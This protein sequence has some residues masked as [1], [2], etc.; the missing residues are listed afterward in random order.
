MLGDRS[1]VNMYRYLSI[2]SLSARVTHLR[3]ASDPRWSYLSGLYGFSGGY[4]IRRTVRPIRLQI[5]K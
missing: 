1:N 4:M 3:V 5:S 2:E